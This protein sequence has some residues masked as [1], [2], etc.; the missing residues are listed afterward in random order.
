MQSN[1][2]PTTS[3]LFTVERVSKLACQFLDTTRASDPLSCTKG[4]DLNTFL[5]HFKPRVK[6]LDWFLK[7]YEGL[8]GGG[9]AGR[10]GAH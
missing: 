8:A 1:A 6:A 4:F 9:G 5:L 2:P 7:S 10:V 3:R